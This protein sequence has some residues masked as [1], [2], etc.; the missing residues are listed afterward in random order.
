[1][2]T[3]EL[4]RVPEIGGLLRRAVTGAVRRG[5]PTA[6]PDTELVVRD[7]AIDRDRLA[8]YARVCGFRLSDRL[9]PTYPH[10]LAFPLSLELMTRP[11]FPFPLIGLVHVANTIEV[12]RPVDAADRLALA[13]RVENLRTHPRGRA[14]DLVMAATVDGEV[15]WRGRSLY[16][17]RESS[18]GAGAEPPR[19][20]EPVVPSTIWKVGADVGP[21]YAAVSG[22]RNPIHTS[23]LA[24]RL[25]GFPRRIA[26][27][28]WTKA[29]CLAAL[30]GRLPDA[31]TVDVSLKL[32]ILLPSTVAFT[33]T[34][35]S[36]GWRIAVDEART[37]RPHLIGS[38]PLSAT[39]EA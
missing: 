6:L 3:E 8:G 35:D 19:P 15:V 5:R 27:G 22:D 26:H 28:M 23:T 33:A 17:R 24:A 7:V 18:P 29:R 9:P 21:A 32:P 2:A 38:I 37:G 36:G 4:D 11:E 14:V 30:E 31:F 13:V 10:V 25:F 20:A 34:E 1:V 16:L 39:G 12:V